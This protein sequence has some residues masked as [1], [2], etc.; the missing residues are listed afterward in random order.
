[1]NY[2]FYIVLALSGALGALSRFLLATWVQERMTNLFPWGTFV[3]NISGCYLLGL[4]YI[5]GINTLIIGPNA[6]TFLAIGFL[7]AYTT[8]STFSL[9][10]LNIIKNGEIKLAL[11]NI[12]ASIIF[13]LIAVWLGT[14][15]GKFIAR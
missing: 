10:T 13:G 7:G 11:L 3:V 15:T 12:I 5:L 9:E 2:T 4:V 6:R 14:V 1:M 8:F